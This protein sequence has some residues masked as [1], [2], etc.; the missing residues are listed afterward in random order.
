[1]FDS[2]VVE[3]GA[4]WNS[5]I[6]AYLIHGMDKNAIALFKQMELM[7]IAP[8]HTFSALPSACAHDGLAEE[9]RK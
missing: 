6:S 9:A 5:M 4:L 8:D 1:M 3:D 2:G 7:G